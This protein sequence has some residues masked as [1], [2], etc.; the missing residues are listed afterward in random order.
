[1]T[2]DP[3]AR[4]LDVKVAITL[5][6]VGYEGE[7]VLLA[8]KHALMTRALEDADLPTAG[9]GTITRGPAEFETDLWFVAEGP[10][11][12][13]APTLALVIRGTQM[14]RWASIK[15]D[16]ELG[17]CDLPFTMPGADPEVKVSHGFAN[18]FD[19][20][21]R[22]SD[23]GGQNALGSSGHGSATAAGQREFTSSATASVARWRGWSASGYRPTSPNWWPPP[24]QPPVSD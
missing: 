15:Q 18:A 1:M 17:L 4:D 22:A 10:D 2:D 11:A 20:L 23:Y 8:K 6:S 24:G 19:R 13:E 12:S 3:M 5:A 21:L 16:L 7:G 14:H 9:R